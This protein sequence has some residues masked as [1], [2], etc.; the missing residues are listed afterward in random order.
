MLYILL[1]A[2]S[3]P[4]TPAFPPEPMGKPVTVQILDGYFVKNTTPIPP[5]QSYVN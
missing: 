4:L 3:L 1:L 2:T 5:T